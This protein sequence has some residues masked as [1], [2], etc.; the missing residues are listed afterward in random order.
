M[1]EWTAAERHAIVGLWG[2][3]NV[4]ELGPLAIQRLL[5]VYP[6]TQR[7]FT[8]FGNVST[9]AAIRGNAKVGHHG[10]V[11]M[12]GLDRAIKNMDN[13]KGVYKDLSVMHS[14]KLHVDPDNFRLLS[15][16]ITVVVA[17]KFGPSVFTPEVQE[18][19][20]KFLNVVASALSRQYH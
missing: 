15:D 14:E 20:Q 3:M 13:I 1:V 9:P 17:E 10:K 6:W 12:G 2:K 18:A 19:W 7:Y 8:S 11:V 4:D 16:C 5:I